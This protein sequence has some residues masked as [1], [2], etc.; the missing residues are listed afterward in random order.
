MRYGKA[1]Y[2]QKNFFK[3]AYDRTDD[4]STIS[5]P[6]HFENTFKFLE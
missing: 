6:N 2:I 1:Y 4:V 3:R 5:Q